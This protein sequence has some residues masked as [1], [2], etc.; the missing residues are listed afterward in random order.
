MGEKKPSIEYF[1]L[2]GLLF[3]LDG[4]MLLFSYSNLTYKNK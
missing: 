1:K 2:D 3:K 4:I